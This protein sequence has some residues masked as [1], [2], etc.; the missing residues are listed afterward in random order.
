AK[1][2][3]SSED[4]FELTERFIGL[5]ALPGFIRKPDTM[6]TP[7]L[8]LL[9]GFEGKRAKSVCETLEVE[10]NNIRVVHGF[11][12][13]RPGWQ[14]LSYGGNQSLFEQFR[15]HRFIWAAAANDPFE[16]YIALDE[17]RKSQE[18][19]HIDSELIL[20]PIGTKPH[21][22]GAAIFALHNPDNTRLIYDFP[23]KARK[24][25]RSEGYGTTWIYNLSASLN[26][27]NAKH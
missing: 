6:K 20:A 16:A 21:S 4:V 14:Y 9:I 5:R 24:F 3:P 7:I 11:P 15:A 19:I 18:K 2:L 23:V 8:V 26:E 1:I 12:G 25:R 10:S 22:I 17:I 13:F 27:N